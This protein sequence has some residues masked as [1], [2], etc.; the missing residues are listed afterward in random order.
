MKKTLFSALLALSLH[1]TAASPVWA[2]EGC[3]VQAV[4]GQPVV[5]RGAEEI[6]LKAGD[7]LQKG[8]TIKTPTP[9]CQVD[10]SMNDLAGIRILSGS[11]AE[12]AAWKTENMTVK[13]V[14]G[15]LIAN[16]QKLPEGSSFKVETPTAIAAVRGTQFW[17]RVQNSAPIPVT[18]FAV[19]EGSVEIQPAGSESVFKLA[20]GQAL[21]IPADDQA[22]KVRDALTEEMA[23]MEQ[24]ASIPTHA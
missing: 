11:I 12:V 1:L 8:D 7:V 5:Q 16:L 6:Q 3:T 18:T 10:M 13:I 19:R 17:G 4:H 21:D 24:A 15:N 2:V 20:A 9:Q 14:N 22:P 23:A